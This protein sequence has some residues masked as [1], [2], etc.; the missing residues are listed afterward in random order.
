VIHRIA[1][2]CE[3]RMIASVLFNHLRA[4]SSKD[5]G[6]GTTKE[7]TQDIYRLADHEANGMQLQPNVRLFLSQFYLSTRNA[8]LL[9]S[10]GKWGNRGESVSQIGQYAEFDIK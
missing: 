7:L 1:F 10:D 2:F 9:V 6:G 5:K 3:L 8:V 4:I